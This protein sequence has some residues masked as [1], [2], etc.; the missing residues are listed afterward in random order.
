MPFVL[1]PEVPILYTTALPEVA[2][3]FGRYTELFDIYQPPPTSPTLSPWIVIPP[4]SPAE[5]WT[6]PLKYK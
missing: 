2:F 3:K 1:E 5:K 6:L 4:I